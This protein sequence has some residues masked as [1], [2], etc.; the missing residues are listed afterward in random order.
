MYI[1]EE[2]DAVKSKISMELARKIQPALSWEALAWYKGRF[3]M[4]SKSYRK[5]AF[6]M[7]R[8]DYWY[9]YTGLTPRIRNYCRKNRIIVKSGKLPFYDDIEITHKPSLPGITFRNDQT[10][11]METV[12]DNKRGIILS[13]TG[14]GKTMLQMGICSAAQDFHI[15]LLAHTVSIVT[16]TVAEFKKYKFTDVQQIGAGAK[17]KKLTGR[18]IIST[19]QTFAKLD[20]K[21][22]ADYFDMVIVDE[23]HHVQSLDSQYGKVMKKIL[24]PF[25]IGFTATEPEKVDQ[26]MVME[27]FFGPTIGEV[28]IKEAIKL[29]ILATPKVKLVKSEFNRLI[30]EE[31]RYP[32]VYDRGIVFNTSRNKQIID[33]TKEHND[34]DETVLIV[35]TK[36][37]HGELLLKMGN[38]ADLKIAFVQGATNLNSRE[39]VKK[40]LIDKNI[41]CVIT[42][43]VWR[44]GI[45]I[46]T[47]GCVINACG[48]KSE[49][50]TLQAIGRG[51][52]KTDDK[53][54]VWIYDFFDPSH[55]YL[56]SHFG[57]RVTLYMEN[58]WL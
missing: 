50:M 1:I 39:E 51:L 20:P 8:P 41:G 3:H 30:K 11:L 12:T 5:D 14:S 10:K 13:P 19:I 44:E 23:V 38:K 57:E 6:Y 53:D 4:E 55:T 56:I 47:L 2:V 21:K 15:L 32:D 58:G 35:V 40:L 52:R 45:N 49:I 7:K 34:K 28:T 42:T 37:R 16:Q 33:I 27:G 46:P 18:I 31:K 9:F 22:Y 54:K 24:A 25:R 29:G 17:S 43:T 36:I 48:G 26:K